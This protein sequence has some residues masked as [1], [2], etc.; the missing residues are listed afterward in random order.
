M[1]RFI[2]VVMVV[3]ATGLSS[4]CSLVDHV[5]EKSIVTK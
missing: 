3:V 1:K 4:G 2:A 5:I